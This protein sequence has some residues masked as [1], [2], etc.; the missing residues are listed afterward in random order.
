MI[1]P[2]EAL[3]KL[4]EGNERFANNKS[5]H[6]NRYEETKDV[7]LKQQKPFV[8]VLSCS[9]S[10][11]PIEIIFDAGLGDIFA[12]RTAGHVL[13]KEVIGSLEY[14]I[15]DLGVKL[16]MILG[17]ENCGA[18]STA[19]QTYQNKNYDELSENLQSIMNHIYPAIENVHDENGDFL[20]CAVKSNIQYQLEDLINKDAY[21]A[22]K[23]QEGKIAVVGAMYSLA[24]GKVEILSERKSNLC[25]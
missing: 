10:R 1:S 13:S 16:V 19:V 15:K 24:K 11:V 20:N 9:D 2:N 17:H 12:V 23:V 6:P 7:L 22:K 8:A 14:A 21:I 18:I 3:K 5:I 4:I 25:R